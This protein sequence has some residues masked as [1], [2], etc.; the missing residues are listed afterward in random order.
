MKKWLFI[1]LILIPSLSF[2]ADHTKTI[3]NGATGQPDFINRIS[4]YSVLDLL[5]GTTLASTVSGLATS[6]SNLSAQVADLQVF[7]STAQVRLN[8]LDSSTATL[9]AIIKTTSSAN[10][11]QFV[12]VASATGALSIAMSTTGAQIFSTYTWANSQFN[13]AFSSISSLATAISTTGVELKNH[14]TAVALSTSILNLTV[15]NT[16]YVNLDISMQTKFGGLNVLGNL[17]VGTNSPSSI[18]DVFNGSITVRGTNAGIV[19]PTFNLSSNLLYRDSQLYHRSGGANNN[20][21]GTS[22]GSLVTSAA[23]ATALGDSSL[24]ALQFGSDNTAIGY[25]ALTL[26]T[27]SIGQ[28]TALGSGA[29]AGIVAGYANVYLGYQTGVT[30][31][32][33][34]AAN[35]FNTAIG[36]SALQ[37]SN[38]G[39][40]N[41]AVGASCLANLGKGSNNTFVGSNFQ[42]GA[43]A[44]YILNTNT[45]VGSSMTFINGT[46]SSTAIGFNVN[47][48]ASDVLVLGRPELTGVSIGD[49]FASSKLDINNGSITI[50]GLNASIETPN[51][52]ASSTTVLGYGGGLVG[53]GTLAPKD[54]FQVVGRV[55]VSSAVV[56]TDG[57]FRK[58]G[59]TNLLEWSNDCVT[60]ST[61]PSATNA[62]ANG[63]TRSG[64][65]EV[66]TTNTDSVTIGAGGTSR[67]TKGLTISQS[68][69]TA[70]VANTDIGDGQRILSLVD[71]NAGNSVVPLSFRSNQAGGVNNQMMD[72]KFV[73]NNDGTSR[74]IYSM[75]PGATFTDRFAFTSSGTFGVGTISPSSILDVNG[76]SITVRGT[77]AGLRIASTGLGGTGRAFDV[78][79]GT[80]TVQ[81]SGYVSVNNISPT[82]T[83]E[84]FAVDASG[85]PARFVGNPWSSGKTSY[86]E[87]GD[88]NHYLGA[89]F[90]GPFLIESSDNIQI[91]TGGG[92][93]GIGTG[94]PSSTFDVFNGSITARGTNAGIRISSFSAIDIAGG[95]FD[96]LITTN[97]VPSM[98]VLFVSA[99]DVHSSANNVISS[100]TITQIQVGNQYLA[101]SSPTV[102]TVPWQGNY[103]F[104]TG[105]WRCGAGD[106]TVE[107]IV[108]RSAAI[109]QRQR[110]DV[111]NVDCGVFSASLMFNGLKSGDTVQFNTNENNAG[112][113]NPVVLT[114]TV[115]YVRGMFQGMYFPYPQQ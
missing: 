24:A 23:R 106:G 64:T 70:F 7:R 32:E 54:T 105:G 48:T 102:L 31:N 94:S 50:R 60:F 47:V 95:M 41:T 35:A 21:F 39:I 86:I 53:I 63:W 29:G 5:G 16:N 113:A 1:G 37:R 6:T 52:R 40:Y 55:R 75:G 59:T 69:M 14:E 111:T 51:F 19:A 84:V 42:P 61:F 13:S 96:K 73:N 104:T 68:T 80:F 107:G 81:Q 11:N 93:V 115:T 18:L 109:A 25:Q 99:R 72:L 92:N 88:S 10:S 74:F 67:A 112:A 2:A 3:F 4:S 57:C 65:V 85:I 9:L 44:D 97:T 98:P 76:G 17:G 62:S 58:N 103:V 101:G 82:R 66:Q 46:S 87:F 12:S 78:F 114:S 71:E 28:N 89:K 20:F 56:G 27:A 49:T 45:A 43:A 22:A 36:A 108:W 90:G 77:N 100:I 34:V 79:D 38:G 8:N 26:N 110:Q 15:S 91:Q 33:I 30:N 83:F